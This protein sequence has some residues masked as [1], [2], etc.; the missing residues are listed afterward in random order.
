LFLQIP[1]KSV[2]LVLDAGNTGTKI[3]P[4]VTR[5]LERRRSVCMWVTWQWRQCK[6]A[7]T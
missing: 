6:L 5:G 1:A 4:R 7:S 3:E 2:L